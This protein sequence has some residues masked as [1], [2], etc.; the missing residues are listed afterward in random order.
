MKT[1]TSILLA[2]ACIP[3]LAALLWGTSNTDIE[4]VKEEC[5]ED[6]RVDGYEEGYDEGFID[7]LYEGLLEGKGSSNSATANSHFL[8]ML[9]E[10]KSYAEE[11]SVDMYF[12]NA[13]DTVSIYLDGYD[14]DG[15]PLPTR[16][17]FEESVKVIFDYAVFLEYSAQEL[18]K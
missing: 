11:M 10:A 15:N 5:Y 1:V 16:K 12:W 9:A 6:G 18:E 14:P 7:G 13:M 3:I 8:Y 4:T 17:E 2:I